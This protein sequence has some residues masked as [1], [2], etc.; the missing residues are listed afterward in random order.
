M[1]VAAFATNTCLTTVEMV[2]AFVSAESDGLAQVFAQV[3]ANNSTITT[4]NLESNSI[5]SAGLEAL[6]AALRTNRTLRELK[7]AN[8][9]TT[10]TQAV[11][12]TIAHALES[13]GTIL[14]PS[15]TPPSPNPP[16]SPAR[17]PPAPLPPHPPH[18]TPSPLA[19]TRHAAAPL[20][21][22]Q[23]D[24]CARP[25][26]QVPHAQPKRKPFPRLGGRR[27]RARAQRGHGADCR[28]A[29]PPPARQGH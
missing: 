6:A 29:C 2:N 15:P 19:R 12:E 16:P 21:R 5:G 8:Q 20:S 14:S 1:V 24:P 11:E 18:S 27:A 10:H 23:V 13:N 25:P 28:A 22:H 4:L 17:Y 26:A 3:L 7:L 9:H